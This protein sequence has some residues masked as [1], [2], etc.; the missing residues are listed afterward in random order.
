[1]KLNRILAAADDSAEGQKAVRAAFSIAVHSSA[2]LSLLHVV[3]APV[4]TFAR[5]Y[6]G[7]SDHFLEEQ[8]SSELRVRRWLLSDDS[9][10]RPGAPPEVSVAYGVPGIEICRFAED[11]SADLIV[12]GRKEHPERTRLSLGDT[13]D[14]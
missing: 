13:G 4:R 9:P 2:T 3:A 11:W 14:A 6:S 8:G 10:A 7:E 5:G 1:M 12:V